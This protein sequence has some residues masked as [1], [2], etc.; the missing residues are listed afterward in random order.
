[1]SYPL[2][3]LPGSDLA[4][5]A[6]IAAGARQPGRAAELTA[7]LIVGRPADQ[8]YGVCCEIAQYAKAAVD[9]LNADTETPRPESGTWTL[10]HLARRPDRT[11]SKR[12]FAEDFLTAY[13]VADDQ[14]AIAVYDEMVRDEQ[15]LHV[16]A[17]AQLICEVAEVTGNA[18][19]HHVAWTR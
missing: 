16:Q 13:C 17:I 10:G 12:A 1:M 4:W 14:S 15:L 3:P 19:G 7:Q 5:R 9:S 6:I 11:D 2:F 18:L 8:M